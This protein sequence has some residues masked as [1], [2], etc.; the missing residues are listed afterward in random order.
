V[1]HDI[2]RLTIVGTSNKPDGK[3]GGQRVA[4]NRRDAQRIANVVRTVEQGDRSGTP[5]TFG[6]K[7]VSAPITFRVATHNSSA[8]AK[9][10]LKTV[11]FINVTTTPNTASAI[12]LFAN[13]ASGSNGRAVA[14]AREGTAW[15]LIAAECS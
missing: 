7:V 5:L 9:D 3:S 13:I 15:Y 11:T 6:R 2:R 4:F 12:N 14:I 10:T 8:W 1:D